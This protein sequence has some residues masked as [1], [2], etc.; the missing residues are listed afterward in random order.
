MTTKQDLLDSL[1]EFTQSYLETALWSSND[2]SRDDG[3][4]PLD[5][6]YDISDF[7][8]ASLKEAIRDCKDFQE[9]YSHLW[10]GEN[11][12]AD[13]G[14]NFWLNRNGHGA[15]F[16]DG[17]YKNGDEL[18]DAAKV[19]GENYITVDSGKLHLE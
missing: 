17:D 6:N 5:A 13:A 19:F 4:D 7:T 10:E 8:A 11:S 16:W 9:K 2:E 14:H 12:D 3:G 18:S 15:G 1:D